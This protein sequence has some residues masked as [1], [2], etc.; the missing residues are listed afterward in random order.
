M[1]AILGDIHGFYELV[2][3]Y[4][5]VAKEAGCNALIQVV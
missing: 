3:N 1:L 4:S 5:K 2:V